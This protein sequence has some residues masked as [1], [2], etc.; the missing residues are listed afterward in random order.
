MTL[1]Q[2]YSQELNNYYLSDLSLL[3][4]NDHN[5]YAFADTLIEYLLWQVITPRD[6]ISQNIKKVQE[7]LLKKSAYYRTLYKNR[8]ILLGV[9]DFNTR[10]LLFEAYKR[11]KNN[12][13]KDFFG[14]VD[15][16]AEVFV[17]KG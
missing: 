10:R 7:F 17:N 8:Q 5:H 15:R 6:E 2:K 9:W 14:Y 1:T 4:I 11:D 3:T 12:P 16:D 13:F